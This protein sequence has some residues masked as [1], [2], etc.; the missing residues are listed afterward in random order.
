M[1]VRY[2][3]TNLEKSKKPSIKIAKAIDFY[4]NIVYNIYLKRCFCV[5]TRELLLYFAEAKADLLGNTLQDDGSKLR[6]Y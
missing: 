5:D 3:F 6:F 4:Y 2:C 1:S